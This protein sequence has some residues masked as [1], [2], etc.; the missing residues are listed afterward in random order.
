MLNLLCSLT[1][2]AL[3]IKFPILL[4]AAAGGG[5]KGMRI[6]HQP[7]DLEANIAA[8]KR[9]AL[10]SFGDDFLIIEKYFSSV[11]HIE[12]QI[13]GD[14]QGNIIHLLERECSIQRRYQKIIEESPSPVLTPSL[15]SAM[16]QAAVN[17]AKAIGYTSA[18][19]VEFI[20][21]ADH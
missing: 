19:T 5:G 11:R 9:E 7:A 1:Q 12:F 16:G 8:A 13:F 15:R 21:T 10:N 20:L 14:N 2:A 17:A 3:K 4:K 6:V 18:G